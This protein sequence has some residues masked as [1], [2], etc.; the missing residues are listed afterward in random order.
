[1][2]KCA[3]VWNFDFARGG[4]NIYDGFASDGIFTKTVKTNNL[5][6]GVYFLNI[7]I[8]GNVRVEKVIKN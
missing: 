4:I 7:L 6:R 1:M 5:A 8:D 3:I 2:G